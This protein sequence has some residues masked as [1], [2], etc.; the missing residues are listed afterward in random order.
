MSETAKKPAA[1]AVPTVLTKVSEGPCRIT[2]VPRPGKAPDYLSLIG[3]DP[4]IEKMREVAV[5]AMKDELTVQWVPAETVLYRKS[6]A[7]S[8]KQFAYYDSRVYLGLPYTSGGKG[9]YQFL[10]YCDP[11]TG[12]MNCTDPV[13]INRCVGNSC[14]SSAAWGLF[15]VCASMKGRCVSRYLTVPNGYFPVGGVRYDPA[16]FDFADHTTKQIL[17]ENGTDAILGAYMAAEPAD[18]L[19]YSEGGPSGGHTMMV[20]GKAH[21]ER[22]ETG[23]IDLQKSYLPT[24]D[25]CAGD[26][27]VEC[28]G[29]TMVQTGRSEHHKTFRYL[30][31]HFYIVVTVGEFTGAVPYEKTRVAL[32]PAPASA[33]DLPAATLRSNRPMATLHLTRGKEEI[34]RY[35]F[36]RDDIGSGEARVFPLAKLIG[37]FDSPLPSSGEFTLTVRA[38]DGAVFTFQ[39][40][41]KNE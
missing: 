40:P 5:R 18:L 34:A 37:G 39:I 8:R 21:V 22:D 2:R 30:L 36:D 14:A 15:T 7:A 9:L 38:A 20:R 28:D 23:A 35:L 1:D 12:A 26:Y 32:S 27:E 11:E 24:Q 17:E 33:K 25:Q 6:G 13:L 10:E 41:S 31:E 29:I 19:V 4:S 3:E 16:L